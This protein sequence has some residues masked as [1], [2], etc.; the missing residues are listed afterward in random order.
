MK[1]WLKIPVKEWPAPGNV[2]DLEADVVGYLAIHPRTEEVALGT[3]SG[4]TEWWAVTHVPSM[5]YIAQFT[6]WRQAASFRKLI[7]QMADWSLVAPDSSALADI[8]A[9]MEVCGGRR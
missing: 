8:L 6:S 5:K 2:I 4:R 3:M 7:K 9:A 1:R